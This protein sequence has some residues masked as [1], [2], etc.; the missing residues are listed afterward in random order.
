[1]F[2]HIQEACNRKNVV[3]LCKSYSLSLTDN[4][5]IKAKPKA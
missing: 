5:N 3:V 4:N 2:T 1:M